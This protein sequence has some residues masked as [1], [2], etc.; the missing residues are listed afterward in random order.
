MSEYFIENDHIRKYS[1]RGSI[2]IGGDL[3]SLLKE[4]RKIE[5]ENNKIKQELEAVRIKEDNAAKERDRYFKQ[6]EEW[7]QL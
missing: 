1:G 4:L 5:K 3:K 7:R 2:G 6:C